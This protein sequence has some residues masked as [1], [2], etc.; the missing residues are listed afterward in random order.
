MVEDEKYLWVRSVSFVALRDLIC[1]LSRTSNNFRAKDINEI[2]AN[3]ETITTH[4]GGKPSA[5]TLYHYRNIL[6]HLGVFIRSNHLYSINFNDQIVA[7]LV[8]LSTPGSQT[9]SIVE[10]ASWGQL[11]LRNSDC[12]KYFFDIFMSSEEYNLQQFIGNGEIVAWQP[13]ENQQQRTVKLFNI[14]NPLKSIFIQTEDEIQAILYGLRYWARNEL[15][16]IDEFFLED[17]G[18]VMFPINLESNGNED[19]VISYIK[20]TVANGGS[21]WQTFSIRDLLFIFGP[22]LKLP[23]RSIH[24]LIVNLQRKFP[25]FVV[26]IPTSEGFATLTA[27]SR[28]SEKYQLRGYLQDDTGRYISHFRIHQKIGEVYNHGK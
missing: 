2:A 3:L 6:L 20:E 9:L 5:T 16:I 17:F 14:K 4:R 21:Q 27:Q 18:G 11:I 8:N 26:F 23:V 22:K 13:V 15:G 7:N 28:V 10:R 24:N 25:E 19:Q 1:A 12:K